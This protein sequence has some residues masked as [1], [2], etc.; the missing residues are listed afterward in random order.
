MKNIELINASAGSGKT[1]NLTSRIVNVIDDGVSPE[2]LMAT[3][4]TKRAAAELKERIRIDLL[5][6]RKTEEAN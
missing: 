1:Y 2:K 3:T 6:N 5:K 4:F